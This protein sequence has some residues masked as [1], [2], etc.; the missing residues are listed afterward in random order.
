GDEVWRPAL[1]RM[2]LESRVRRRRRAI[3]FAGLLYPAAEQLRVFGFANDDLRI[4]HL[5]RQHPRYTLQRAASAVSGHPIVEPVAHEILD[6]LARRRA[7][8]NVGVGL[9]LEL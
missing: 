7:G 1:H 3:Q 9:V 6:D 2:R 8:M 4:G 5:L